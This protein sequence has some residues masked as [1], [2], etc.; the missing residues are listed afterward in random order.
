MAFKYLMLAASDSESGDPVHPPEPGGLTV[1]PRLQDSLSEDAHLHRDWQA[2][3]QL[4]LE[5]IAALEP[6]VR[7]RAHRPLSGY[8]HS[9]VIAS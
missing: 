9:K 5:A 8:L 3:A 6:L 4:E 2:R 7:T 1:R